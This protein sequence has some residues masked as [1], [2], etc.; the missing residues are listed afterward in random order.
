MFQAAASGLNVSDAQVTV[1]ASQATK[2]STTYSIA[3]AN[4]NLVMPQEIVIRGKKTIEATVDEVLEKPPGSP[5]QQVELDSPKDQK[6]IPYIP[7]PKTT[8]QKYSDMEADIL[9]E[10]LTSSSSS[11]GAA[12]TP[13]K[14]VSKGDKSKT[15]GTLSDIMGEISMTYSEFSTINEVTVNDNEVWFR[16]CIH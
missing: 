15:A 14:N 7:K 13:G 12:K 4:P 8:S 5:K 1:A 9:E 6:P 10:D 3:V 11:A 16:S 2:Q